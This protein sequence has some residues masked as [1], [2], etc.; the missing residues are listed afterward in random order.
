MAEEP[1]GYHLSDRAGESTA[2]LRLYVEANRRAVVAGLFVAVLLVLL[3][4][5]YGVPGAAGAA[6]SDTAIDTLFQAL[7][8]ATI[9]GVTL[10]LTLN[11]LVLSQELGAAGD[12]R[13]RM[14][15]AV[16]FRDDAADALA[17][18]VSP[19][20]PSR[21]VRAFVERLGDRARDLRAAVGGPTRSGSHEGGG[22]GDGAGPVGGD[23]DRTLTQEVDDFV[24]GIEAEVEH[25]APAL[26]DA[27][28]GEF[29]VLSAALDLDY[30]R[31]QFAA[32]RIRAEYED[33]LSSDALA[34]LDDVVDLLGLYGVAREHFKTLYF[35][36]TLIDLSQDILL[37]ALPALVVSASM[38]VFFNPSAVPARV[39][40][41]DPLP[42]ILAA[43]ITVAALPFLVLLAYVLRVATVTK[44]T[45]SIGP[46]LLRSADRVDDVEID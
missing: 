33:A 1:D 39:V 7:V 18:P 26:R 16:S 27:Q 32:R 45:L 12:Q 23:E 22:P 13:E 29:E 17:L 5:A 11:Q 40:G 38:V 41:L 15:K 10:V 24:D 35:Q 20:V 3:A 9:T 43:A 4:I 30:A 42:A 21:F 36:W 2:K 25:V 34:I 28:F 31:Q 46:F 19:A 37:A 14:E 44:Y 6:R 8:T